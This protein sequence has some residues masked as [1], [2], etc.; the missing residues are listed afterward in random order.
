MNQA[1]QFKWK[2]GVSIMQL[3]HNNQKNYVI[4]KCLKINIKNSKSTK[5]NKG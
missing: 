3:L 4:I 2:S 5:E 1:K